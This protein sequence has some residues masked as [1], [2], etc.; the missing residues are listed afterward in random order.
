MKYFPLHPSSRKVI[1]KLDVLSWEISTSSRD[2]SLE[3]E[4]FFIKTRII[5]AVAETILEAC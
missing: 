3:T 1:Q 2:L 4:S 5:H